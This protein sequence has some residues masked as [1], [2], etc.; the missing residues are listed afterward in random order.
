[1]AE[2][3]VDIKQR[4]VWGKIAPY[5][6]NYRSESWRDVK[7]F[8]AELLKDKSGKEK[9]RNVLEVGCGN[10]RNLISF[11]KEKWGCFGIDFAPAMIKEAEKNALKNKVKI[12]FK[13]DNITKLPYKD[14]QFEVVLC[15]AVLHC[16]K[17]EQ[18]KKSAERNFYGFKK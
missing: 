13:I 16:L 17:K 10:A 8:I 14:A 4:E 15:I 2:R 12:Y 3:V 18:Q 6:N 7:K 5:W 1:M 9:K 11:A